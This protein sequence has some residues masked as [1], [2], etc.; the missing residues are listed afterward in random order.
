[1]RCEQ[2][3]GFRLA[4]IALGVLLVSG[5]GYGEVS[6]AAY[7]YAKALYGVANREAADRLDG[8]ADQIKADEASGEITPT[9]AEWLGEI[10]EQ[11]RAGDW[12]GAAAAARRMMQD[13]VS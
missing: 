5:C 7:E 4:A 8:V 6:P 2:G 10:V 12:P 3:N 13:Q 1:M 9:E 11:A